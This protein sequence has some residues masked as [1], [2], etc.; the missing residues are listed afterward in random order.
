MEPRSARTRRRPR[1]PSA[2]HEA[3]VD[4]LRR[5]IVGPEQGRLERLEERPNICAATIGE[6][7]PE[8]VATATPERRERLAIALEPTLTDAIRTVARRDAAFFGEI[9]APSIGA[10]VRKAVSEAIATITQKFNEALERSLSWRSVQWRIEAKRTGQQFAEVVLLHT[11]V[12]RV[13]EV[14]LIHPGTGLVLERVAAAGAGVLEPDQVAAML[15]AIDRFVHEAFAPLPGGVHIGRIRFGDFFLWVERAPDVAVAALVRGVAPE[16]FATV[17]RDTRERIGL[18]K[19]EE[20]ARFESNVTPFAA[21]RPLLDRCM[22]SQRRPAPG[23]AW[24]WLAVAA[25]GAALAFAL[26]VAG[27]RERSVAERH[28]LQASVAT[29]ASEP[30]IVVTSAYWIGHRLR[31]RGLRDPLASAPQQAL[32]ERGLPAADIELAPYSS[33]DPA[34]IE[35][36][37]RDKLAPPRSVSLQVVGDV[38]HAR[39]TAPQTWIDDARRVAPEIAGVD[40]YDDGDLRSQQAVDA[41]TEAADAL[42]RAQ[43]VFPVGSSDPALARGFSTA[44]RSATRVVAAAAAARLDACMSVVGHSD[45]SGGAAQN[46]TL[47][48]ARARNVAASLVAEGIARELVRFT[49]AGVW[50][51][52]PSARAA[53]SVTFL[54]DVGCKARP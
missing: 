2:G 39:G 36:R 7:L 37:A 33:L 29:L 3:T 22:T 5:L 51:N 8:A 52:A 34:I 41:L 12:Y 38:L 49:G 10:A 15:E 1:E 14:F 50:T 47:S 28:V 16:A 9:L 6:V 45:P 25:G 54:V 17:L 43:V 13:Q 11:L 35:R 40:R 23:R 30:G 46:M 31:I 4:D 53:R 18:A 48:E 27:W 24:I 42:N 20:L 26:L 32:A 44:R 21:V 19:K